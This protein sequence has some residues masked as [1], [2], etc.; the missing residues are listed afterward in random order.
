MSASPVTG[1]P[2]S[3]P[4]TV[5]TS[6]VETVNGSHQFTIKG[7][8]LAK[9]MGPGKYIQ[10]D[11]FVIGGYDWAIYFYPDGKNPEDSS[12][13]VSVFI[14][15]AS[16]SNDVRAL[17]ELSLV[18]QS[19]KG[20]H[21]VHSHFDRALEGGPYTLKYKG[22][23]W[24]YKRFFRR[25]TLEASD[26][27]KDDCLVINCTVGVVRTRLE[28]PKQY[29]IPLPPSNMGQGLKDLLDS[30]VGCDIAFQVREETYKAHKLILAARSPVFR[31]QFFGLV[32]DNSVDRIVIDDIE[33]S[34][35][36]A[37]LNFIYTDELP[38][39]N[40]ITGSVS[41]SSF[42]N[43]VQHLLAAADLYDLGRLKILC[44]AV[45]CEHLNV[46]NVATTLALAEQ[47]QFS[48]LK[49]FCLKFAASSTNLG[50]VMQ[51]EGFKHLE[52]CCPSL[53]SELLKA[54][55][56]GDDGSNGQ[57]SKKR[58]GSSVMGCD[59]TLGTVIS[60]ALNPNTRRVRRRN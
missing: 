59:L 22:S 43:M 11:V 1:D 46:D 23:M 4:D 7:Y 60:E 45:L 27:L 9:G 13:Y 32:G 3:N 40:E 52:E 20:K 17:F 56:A 57:L 19:G 29:H 58:S 6:I 41:P 28:G 38:D 39:V 5:S 24:G 50:A 15:L 55:A 42:T 36:K 49:T 16:E 53:L 25:T 47:H 2:Q 54:Y 18:D 37:M 8:S 21:K 44:E 14:A 10:S 51:S 12:V 35:F 48:Q 34:I 31:A 33:P 30:E 26:F